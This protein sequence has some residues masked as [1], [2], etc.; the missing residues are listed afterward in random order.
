MRWRSSAGRFPGVIEPCGDALSG[1]LMNAG[2]IIHP[3]LISR[4]PGRSSIP[5]ASTFTMKAPSLDPPGH[6]PARPR[7]HRRTRGAGLWPAALSAGRPLR[8]RRA[9]NQDVWPR[10]A[11]SPH[12]FGDW[13]ERILLTE[14]RYMREDPLL[15]LSLLVSV[16]DLAGV[17]RRWRNHF[18]PS[19]ARSAGRIS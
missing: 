10:R 18:S 1:A 2:P 12:P 7:A 9:T 16:A 14:H 11:R 15:G 19:A 4:T 8:Q 17:G 13:R 5:S 3:P 6:P